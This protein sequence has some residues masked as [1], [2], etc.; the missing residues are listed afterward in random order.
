MTGMR[1]NLVLLHLSLS[2]WD[3]G[4][5][6]TSLTWAWWTFFHSLTTTS[7]SFHATS[8]ANTPALEAYLTTSQAYLPNSL[9]NPNLTITTKTNTCSWHPHFWVE[10]NP[11]LVLV[12]FFPVLFLQWPTSITPQ[13]IVCL[14]HSLVEVELYLIPQPYTPCLKSEFQLCH[15]YV[16]VLVCLDYLLACNSCLTF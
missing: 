12:W 16:W 6:L 3:P 8:E 5:K 13:S 7:D 10:N 11:L 1:F 15:S 2:Y 4:L 14:A 9:R